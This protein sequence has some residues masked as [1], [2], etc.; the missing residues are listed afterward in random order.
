MARPPAGSMSKAQWIREGIAKN[1]EMKSGELADHLTNEA[2]AKGHLG[3]GVI[4]STEVSFY[5]SKAK[6][7][8]TSMNTFPSAPIHPAPQDFRGL[9]TKL[10]VE[11][12]ENALKEAVGVA[13]QVKRLID[14]YGIEVIEDLVALFRDETIKTLP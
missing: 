10:V 12:D 11:D 3:V 2:R 8:T 7:T 13:H 14:K 1:P 4:K 5:R 6:G 9:V